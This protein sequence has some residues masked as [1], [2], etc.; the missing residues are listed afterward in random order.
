M[1]LDKEENSLNGFLIIDKPSGMTSHS[2]VHQIR[3]I[4]NTKKVG[5]AGTLDPD[6]TGVLVVGLG[7]ATRLITYLV[8]D[9]KT[10]QATIRLG[11]STS[12]DDREGEILKT[13]DCSNLDENEINSVILNFIGDIHQIPSAVSAIK[14][15]GQK[16]YDLVR[17]G[18][19]VELKPRKIHISA[20]D[21]HEI[22]KVN[23][24]ID[25][26]LTIHCSSGTYI[27]ALARDI[28]EQLK[29]GGHVTNLRRLQSGQWNISDAKKI[30]ELKVD[31]LPLI[32]M[33]EIATT[34][35]P[36]VKVE[37]EEIQDLIHGRYVR[38]THEPAET[39][40]L[41]DKKPSL[42]ALAHGDGVMLKPQIVFA[43]GISGV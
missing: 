35:F 40:A 42:V 9:N 19:K 22:K 16:A 30:E 10:Y 12:T 23:S 17:K 28:G 27:R 14:I 18:E 7:K 34:M 26:N 25:L 11:Q 21:I 5:H 24:Y 3:K 1:N 2:V 20:I 32:S 41:I 4:T 15:N 8:S 37:F 31:N 33:A 36:S 38:K 6:A 43:T 39:I 13:V 29:V